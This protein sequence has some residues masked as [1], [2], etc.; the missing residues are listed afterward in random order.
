MGSFELS[1]QFFFIIAVI[2]LWLLNNRSSISVFGT[3]TRII[4]DEDVLSLS[5]ETPMGEKYPDIQGESVGETPGGSPMA[6]AET[7]T[8][9]S[10]QEIQP[11]HFS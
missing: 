5:E 11:K 1:R 4:F 6:G 10:D 3:Q 8:S 7:I 2:D 9:D